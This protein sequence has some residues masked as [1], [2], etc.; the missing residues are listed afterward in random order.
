MKAH[1]IHLSLALLMAV[2]VTAV[3]STSAVSGFDEGVANYRIGNYDGAFREWTESAAQGDAD[4]QY[5]LGCLFV[6]GE[7]APPDT[8]RAREWLRKAA[9]QD[10]GDSLS[11]LFTNQVAAG[12]LSEDSRKSFFSKALKLSGRFHI[13]YVAQ[14]ENGHLMRWPCATDEKNGA[15]TQFKIALMYEKGN[16]GLPQDDRQAAEWYRKAAGRNFAVAQTRLAYM[17]AA[18]RGIA[19][20]EIEAARLFRRAA[21]LGDAGAQDNLGAL[22]QQGGF[23]VAQ[24]L[25]LA[26]VL[27]S[28]A[29]DAGNKLSTSSLAEL[30]AHLSP[31][32][33]QEGQRLAA[34]WKGNAPYPAEISERLRSPN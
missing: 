30:K 31:D 2:A 13:T 21:E 28:H 34:K 4:A 24:D 12:Q 23:G 17:Y 22:Y 6:R 19:R 33:L 26:Y 9:D 10:E 11:W 29:A 5:N 25:V 15:E 8:D 14:L 1:Q 7:G 20:N 3:S 32:Q 18:G 27:F 16:M